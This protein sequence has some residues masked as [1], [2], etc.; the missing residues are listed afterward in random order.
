MQR[1]Y[2]IMIIAAFACSCMKTSLTGN[3][4]TGN[5]STGNNDTSAAI[6][7]IG[8][9]IGSPVTKTIGASGGTIISADGRAEL[10]IPAGA[11]SSDLAISIQPITNECPNGV[12]IA[13]DFLPNGT[14]FLIPATFTLHYTDDDI[15]GTD[16]YLLNLAFQD[17]LNEWQVDIF[18]DVDTIGKTIIFD[19]S[20]FSGRAV[21]ADVKLGPAIKISAKNGTDF[22][23]NK[24]GV[25][26]VSQGSTPGQLAG[27]FDGDPDGLLAPLP[28]PNPISDDK[29]SNWTLNPPGSLLNGS[30]SA[31]K[32]S[33]VTYTAPNTILQEKTVTVFATVSI[34]AASVSRRRQKSQVSSGPEVLKL[35]LHLH[36]TNM[37]FSIKVIFNATDVSGY[38]Q[39][40]YHDE[41]TFEVDVK[42]YL[43]KVPVEKIQNSA[44]TVTPPSFVSGNTQVDWQ[45]DEY[46]V[47]NITGSYNSY[48]ILD[49]LNFN[50]RNVNLYITHSNT[51]TPSF[52]ITDLPTKHVTPIEGLT[53]P[54]YPQA[55]AFVYKDSVQVVDP[56]KGTLKEGLMTVTITPIH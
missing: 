9:P 8:T 49:S 17:S 28:K 18:K 19:I 37:S 40:K 13:Y 24:Q 23:E 50:Q 36:P 33:T 21:Q 3:N 5:N 54:G 42:N 10:N 56:L 27:D 22:T 6:T 52:N 45:P 34:H 7:A 15:N 16:P 30:L 14:K 55:L 2:T 43:V 4:S 41:A 12:G 26:V 38:G 53:V 20:H 44:P 48:T 29:V 25:F 46:G 35:K 32:G 51:V 1:L 31:T 39:D 47:I 11:L